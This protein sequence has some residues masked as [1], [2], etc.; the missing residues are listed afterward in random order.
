M[1]CDTNPARAAQYAALLTQMYGPHHDAYRPVFAVDGTA[2]AEAGLAA[3][4]LQAPACRIDK[5][6]RAARP[7]V[8]VAMFA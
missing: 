5:R 7:A 1:S 6:D 4:D 8:D 2:G 3:A